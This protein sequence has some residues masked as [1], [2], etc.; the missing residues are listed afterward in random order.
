MKG[1]KYASERILVY[2]M[3]G[4]NYPTTRTIWY[5]RAV[6]YFRLIS[7][8]ERSVLIIFDALKIIG[9]HNIVKSFFQTSFISPMKLT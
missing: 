9:I 4:D 8:V 6:Y 3:A 5:G 7:V 1:L 2:Y